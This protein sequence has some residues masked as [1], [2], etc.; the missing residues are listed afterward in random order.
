M[1][2]RY[3]ELPERRIVKLPDLPRIPI[4][5]DSDFHIDKWPTRE[6]KYE[7]NS[8]PKDSLLPKEYEP[9]RIDTFYR[10]RDDG[11]EFATMH[12]WK[13]IGDAA[14]K[15]RETRELAQRALETLGNTA[16]GPTVRVEGLDHQPYRFIDFRSANRELRWSGQDV[17]LGSQL[18]EA[19]QDM[20]EPLSVHGTP[21]A[22]IAFAEALQR[23]MQETPSS[24][25]SGPEE[26]R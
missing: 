6:K 9:K 19:H 8:I 7:L 1:P 18:A 20:S 16:T 13:V 17:P 3:D 25:P 11:S 23:A 4:E 10:P 24:D 5:Q 22:I 21:E 15:R 14:E 2:S 26:E 12:F